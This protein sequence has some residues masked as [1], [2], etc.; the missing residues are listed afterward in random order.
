MQPQII[1]KSDHHEVGTK[2]V[3][4]LALSS[5]DDKRL[6]K[7]DGLQHIHMVQMLLKYAKVKCWLKGKLY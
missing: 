1:F 2:K 6:Q 3:N 5:N 7:F 4:I